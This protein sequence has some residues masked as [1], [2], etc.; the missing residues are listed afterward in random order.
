MET[1]LAPVS[2]CQKPNIL[3]FNPVRNRHGNHIVLT[4]TIRLA[5]VD[6]PWLGQKLGIIV[7]N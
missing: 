2:L 5:G 3:I 4:L 1:L 7:L 6:G